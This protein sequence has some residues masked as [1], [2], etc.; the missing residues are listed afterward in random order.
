LEITEF[1]NPILRKKAKEVENIDDPETQKLIN[2]MMATVTEVNGVGLASPQVNRSLRI[3][4]ISSHPNTR[5]PDAPDVTPREIINPV[6]TDRS[7][8]M[9]KDWEGC[10]SIPGIRGIVPRHKEIKV[11]YLNRQGEEN[12]EI[13]HHFIARV[14]QHELDHLDGMVFLD[15]I[16]NNKD[17]ITE[18][19]YR[20]MLQQNGSNL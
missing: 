10:L 4:I 5:Y 11:K 3:F 19:E 15:R 14:F 9:E 2:D 1:G 6:I 20:K 13:F 17:I 8:E 7:E 16:R 12:S 18:T